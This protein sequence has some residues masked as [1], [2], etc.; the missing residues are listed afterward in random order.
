MSIIWVPAILGS[1]D[2]CGQDVEAG[3]VLRK[4]LAGYL[5]EECLE[6]EGDD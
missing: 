4:T 3:G 2:V 5:C 1:C 6:E